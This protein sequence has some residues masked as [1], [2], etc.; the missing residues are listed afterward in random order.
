[1]V[2]P[3]ICIDFDG[4]L[5]TYTKWEGEDVYPPLRPGAQDFLKFTQLYFRIIIYSCRDPQKL[6]AYFLKEKLPY[7]EIVQKPRAIFYIDDHAYPFKSFRDCE[8]HYDDWFAL[9]K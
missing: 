2:K 9:Y 8:S 6:K 3:S 1:M 7:D 4:V 5:N